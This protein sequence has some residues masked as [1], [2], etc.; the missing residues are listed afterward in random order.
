M[1]QPIPQL[2]ILPPLLKSIWER[3]QS[4]I[5]ILETGDGS[6]GSTATL[7]QWVAYDE[8]KVD[9]FKSISLD[10]AA[11]ERC[12]RQLEIFGIS[13]YCTFHMQSPMKWL[14]NLNW[15]DFVL[16]NPESLDDGVQQFA[17]AISAG[18][19]IVVIHDYQRG[20]ALAVRK[21]YGLGW[22][23]ENTEIYSILRR[24]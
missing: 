3:K 10:G 13:P 11:Q 2:A 6:Y 12:H 19:S 18:V 23:V 14:S 8:E 4:R 17:L 9:Y 20:A 22:T 5:Q 16:L 15:L 24:P 7:A 21:A 1:Y